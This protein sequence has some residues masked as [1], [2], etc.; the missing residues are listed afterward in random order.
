MKT[1]KIGA[2]TASYIVFSFAALMTILTF[3][4]ATREFLYGV[5]GY[6][7]YAYIPALLLTGALMYSGRR[8]QVGKGRAALYI[9]LLFAAILTL[10][11]GLSESIVGQSNY[12]SATYSA[13]TVGGVMIGL[14]AALLHLIYPNY[15]FMLV[16]SLILTATLLFFA[17]YPF[18]VSL[19]SGKKSA[20][21]A[22]YTA[23]KR[24]DGDDVAV[25]PY[26]GTT[27]VSR[28]VGTDN[29]SDLINVTGMD[30]DRYRREIEPE[31]R[32][33]SDAHSIL[34]N[35]EQ[36]MSDKEKSQRFISAFDVHPYT[37]QGIIDFSDPDDYKKRYGA[38]EESVPA[39]K[40][41]AESRRP[42]LYEVPVRQESETYRAPAPE[43]EEEPESALDKLY[44]QPVTQESDN[45]S[46]YRQTENLRPAMPVMPQKRYD[47]YGFEIKEGDVAPVSR[48]P[49]PETVN[50][51]NAYRS[52]T[53]SVPR[54][55]DSAY[56][57]N[58]PGPGPMYNPAGSVD[59][60]RPE[61]RPE[62]VRPSPSP[63]PAPAEKPYS[64]SA[65]D[66]LLKPM[67]DDEFRSGNIFGKVL[68]EE[69]EKITAADA[70]T[71]I[72]AKVVPPAVSRR[73][74]PEKR[75][76]PVSV[77][78]EKK[79][80]F[81]SDALKKEAAPEFPD[82]AS[83]AAEQQGMFPSAPK[84]PYVPK[85]YKAPPY[86]LLNDFGSSGSEFPSDY[87][88]M[89]EKIEMTMQ[90]FNVPAVVETAKRGPTFTMYY[91]KLG[92]GYK[93][94]K[95]TALKDNLKMR[96]RVKNLRILAPIEGED[97]FGIELPNTKRD[98]VGLKSLLCS[99][100]FNKDSS[101]I[102]IAMGKSFDG[103]PYVANLAKM[104]HL[105]VAGATGTGK[106]VFLNSVIISILYKYSPEDVRIVMI[107][108]KRVEMSIYKGL[109]NLL[110]KEPVKESRHAAN[111]L[112]WLTE[113][114]D[115]RYSFFE[116]V[117]CRDIDQYN[118]V[119]RDKATEPKM[120]KIVLIIDEMADLMVKSKN[121]NVEENIV[122]LAQLARACGIHMIIATQ[123]PTAQ[124][125]TGLI[126]TNI[127]HR[128]AFTVKS[129]LD[130][131]VIM[132]DGGAEDLLGNGDM[133]YSFPAN[134]LRLQGAFVDIQE[135]KNIVDYIK[136][137]NECDYD[138]S[139]LQSITYEPPAPVEEV[140]SN[141]QEARDAS[142]E[143][144]LRIILKSFI[145]EGRAS[146][147]NAQA[148]HGVGYIKAKKLVDEMEARGFIGPQ[149]GA[150]TRE[151]LITLDE[152]YDIFGK[153]MDAEGTPSANGASSSEE[154]DDE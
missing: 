23:S 113:E 11:V 9:T 50:R 110:V 12:L 117:G 102:K 104:P 146:V 15:A 88:E 108:P 111:A 79:P 114:M 133:L 60:Y 90:E 84:K 120:P 136:A 112:K 89:K 130:S 118:D 129:N 116:Q 2:R 44:K 10:H 13:H 126:K 151:I 125:I 55:A 4:S 21:P 127:L 153:D 31:R 107:D 147:S 59:G 93:I 134:I 65:K 150:K 6:A 73:P 121:N 94:N 97:A 27:S 137:N 26:I 74:E 46:G 141:P 32:S 85:P 128:V 99:E 64:G 144:Q 61:P 40:S 47:Q 54:A 145:I 49:A 62:P 58:A 20:R 14:P 106:S 48:Q 5:F 139:I 36:P 95:V 67:S 78:R 45:L 52:D 131:R 1:N 154:E 105:L 101:G 138:D 148:K 98:I 149:D 140:A 29:D 96:L 30:S 8:L 51:E 143:Q 33:K 86:D 91:L 122:R 72:E 109:P 18:V 41:P 28:P 3:F 152:F 56:R 37:N 119:F 63:A 82:S 39:E 70:D 19:G 142:F 76:A 83:P 68:E 17:I 22:S 132:D 80:E 123:R 103:Q 124:V 75:E 115:R 38:P 135:I 87:Q 16:V 24:R 92:D 35:G 57:V 71:A 66:W 25:R 43:K 34:F 100:A 77:K 42:S 81:K 53:V 7:V 69:D